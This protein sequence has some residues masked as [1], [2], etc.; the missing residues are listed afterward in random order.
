MGDENLS[1][2]Q[3][4]SVGK[5][6]DEKMSAAAKK[7]NATHFANADL[8]Q[9]AGKK[10]S[11]LWLGRYAEDE[12]RRLLEKFNILSA[13]GAKGF[14]EIFIDVE[15]IDR[16]LQALKIFSAKP[17]A[18]NLLAEF[19][20]R[21][22]PFS[23]SCFANAAP[24]NVLKI[25]WLMLQNPHVD[26]SAER[27][28]LPG[29]HHPGLGLSRHVLQLLI[30]LT[31]TQQLAGILNFPEF[32]HNAYFYFEH[33]YFCDPRLKG[34]VLSLRRD[35]NELSVAELSWAVYLGCVIDANTEETYDWQAEALVLPLDEQFKKYFYSDEYEQIVRD[36]MAVSSF[37]LHRDKFDKVLLD[38]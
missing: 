35:L 2:R 36:T 14:S 21:E 4:S 17:A 12:I 7:K 16:F 37:V 38:S 13:L 5:N 9:L 30:H 32:F 29:Q 3:S 34:L 18:E 22:A 15:P 10:S 25:E 11:T 6:R 19:R 27:P 8:E 33:F 31:K 24:L 1:R 20:L 23:H 26:F 28:R